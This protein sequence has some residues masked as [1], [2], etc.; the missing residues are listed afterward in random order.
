[1]QEP[2]LWL[3]A[4]RYGAGVA[5]RLSFRGSLLAR[6]FGARLLDAA[7]VFAILFALVVV[8]VLWFMDTAAGRFDPQPWGRAFA[9]TVTFVVLHAV[10]ELVFTIA[11]GQTPG[12][13]RLDLRV[14]SRADGRP[15][16]WRR[17]VLR[18]APLA[19]AMMV[20]PVW[21][22]ALVVVAL[23]V[24]AAGP[25][26]RAVHDRLAGTVVV[27]YDADVEEGPLPGRDPD[28][29]RRTYGPR[30]VLAQLVDRLERR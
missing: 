28:A 14:E 23:G 12:K 2:L 30:S 7:T 18:F 13:D 8:R 4:A 3:G 16:G 9:P 29:V 26:G 24:G 10:Y 11:R 5:P 21:L 6:R 27:D 1:M 19:I 15:P 25:S 22:G 17:A 20:P